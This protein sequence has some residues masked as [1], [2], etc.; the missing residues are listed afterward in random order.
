[1]ALTFQQV[2]D[3]SGAAKLLNQRYAECGFGD[4]AIPNGA[5]FVAEDNGELVATVT[6]VVE[7]DTANLVRLVSSCNSAKVLF[8][9]FKMAFDYGTMT[10][11]DCKFL[12]VEVHPRHARFYE[13]VFGCER[14]GEPWES[15]EYNSPS[16]LL[17]LRVSDI[18]I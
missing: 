16:Q 11:P 12:T 10:Y 4:H 1:M 2:T 15:E 3:T 18:R 13:R 8:G 7:G 9:L 5:T 6:L 17:R 14:I